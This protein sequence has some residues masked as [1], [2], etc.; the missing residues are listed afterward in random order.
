MASPL[1][2][3]HSDDSTQ[4]DVLIRQRN[5]LFFLS[6]LLF[7]FSLVDFDFVL[8]CSLNASQPNAKQANKNT[9]TTREGKLE[10]EE[11]ILSCIE[12]SAGGISLNDQS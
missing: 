7:S 6:L 2:D 11:I 8:V 10:R 5:T 4:N 9:T 12:F 1:N 3:F